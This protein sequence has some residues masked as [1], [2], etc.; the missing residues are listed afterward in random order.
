MYVTLIKLLK[1]HT[2]GDESLP[3]PMPL[4]PGVV[5]LGAPRAK[6]HG[7]LDAL[8]RV[9]KTAAPGREADEALI[10]NAGGEGEVTLVPHG[11]GRDVVYE[12]EVEVGIPRIPRVRGE[13]AVVAAQI[14]LREAVD[15]E[16]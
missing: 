16:L 14:A 8:R 15:V 4:A 5:E 13:H 3:D 7:A 6:L 1:L 10:A 12:L 2:L 11:E 9:D